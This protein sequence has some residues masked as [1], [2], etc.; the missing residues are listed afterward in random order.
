MCVCVCVCV[1]I[2]LGRITE[3]SGSWKAFCKDFYKILKI[4]SILFCAKLLQWCPTVCN[5]MTCSLPD[6]SVHGILQARILEWVA[7]IFSR[8]SS[9]LKDQ[10]H[11]SYISDF[12]RL[13]LTVWL[14]KII[15][16]SYFFPLF[17]FFRWYPSQ[18]VI[19]PNKKFSWTIKKC[20]P[21]AIT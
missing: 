4:I 9:W 1:Y 3:W 17:S 5:P 8:E 10:T 14:V 19:L 6:S 20:F 21:S 2:Y 13:V 7:M 12:G 16:L 18:V 15:P 11:G